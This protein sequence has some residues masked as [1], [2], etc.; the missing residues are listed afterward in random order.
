LANRRQIA[1][2]YAEA[3]VAILLGTTE[4]VTLYDIS[5][6]DP[7]ESD[8]WSRA[9]GDFLRLSIPFR[10]VLDSRIIDIAAALANNEMIV[11]PF[12][13]FANQGRDVC[14][15]GNGRRP[16]WAVDQSA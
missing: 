11:L 7:D 1:Q 14:R 2:L 3:G 6:V 13:P 9:L 10:P 15:F 4:I 8:R 5:A 16:L 12:N